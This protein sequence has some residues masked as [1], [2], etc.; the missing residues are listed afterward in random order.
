MHIAHCELT[1]S[2]RGVGRGMRWPAS[3]EALLK[4]VSTMF[5]IAKFLYVIMLRLQTAGEGRLRPAHR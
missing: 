3:A 5:I 1:A 2:D 4:R